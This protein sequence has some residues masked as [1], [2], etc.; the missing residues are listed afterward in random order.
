[1]RD[2]RSIKSKATARRCPSCDS[3]RITTAIVNDEFLYGEEPGAVSIPVTIP[4]HTCASCGVQFTDYVAEELR[5]EAVCRYLGVLTPAEITALR[6]KH[7]LS[8]AEFAA[9]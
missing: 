9:L 8:R 5:Q 1:M 3:E 4:V 7:G 6:R 2:E